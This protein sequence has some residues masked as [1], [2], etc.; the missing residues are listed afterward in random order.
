[1]NQKDINVLILSLNNKI[2]KIL[3]NISLK[4][5]QQFIFSFKT[6]QTIELEN[7]NE[8]DLV[9]IDD[10]DEK[11]SILKIKGVRQHQELKKIPI[12]VLLNEKENVDLFIDTGI[13]DY[14]VKPYSTQE[15][16][17]K[18][19]NYVGYLNAVKESKNRTLQFDALLNNTPYMA[20]FKNKDSQYIKVNREFREHSGKE[21]DVIFGRDDFFVWDGQIGEACREY[22]L[23]VMNERRQIIFDEV[24][25]GK[26]GYRQFNIYKAPVIDEFDKVVGTI[27]I[28]RDVTEL[29]NKDAKLNM[30]LE[31]IP[32]AVCLKDLN[33]TLIDVNSK[34]LDYYKVSRELVIG[35]NN[36][37]I[38][39]SL[40][41]VIA[42]EDQL[43]KQGMK[44]QKFVRTIELF[45]E[46]RV[47][48]VYKSPVFDISN[49]IIAI[50]GL[51]RDITED[52]KTQ[53]HIKTLAYTDFL[54]GLKNRR[55]LY[56]YIEKEKNYPET[57]LTVMFMDLDNF[58]KLND[59]FG[60]HYGDEALL[61][62]SKKLTALC[63][64][65]FVARIGGD[66]FVVVWK[67]IKDEVFLMNKINQIL[68]E[69]KTEFNKG[70]QSNII[71]VSMGVVN[72]RGGEIEVDHLL[73]QGDLALYKAKEKGKNQCVIY[74]DDLEKERLFAL[75]LEMD[76]R[77]AIKN[78]EI[79]LYY[80]PQY[81]CDKKLKGFEALFRW[82]NQKYRNVSVIDIIKMIEECHMID[83]IGDYVIEQ[84]CRFSKKINQ[85]VSEPL[86]VSMNIS[87]LQI[88][89]YNFVD[90]FKSFIEKVNISPSLVG[91]EI[92]ETV[93][94]E[95]MKENTKKLKELKELGV[96]ISLD[97]FGTGYSSLNYLVHLPLSQI[98]IDRSFVRGMNQGDEFIK[99]VKLIINIAHTLSLPIIAEGVEYE[100]DLNLLK[101]L[102]VDYI[103][104]YYFSKPVCEEEAL[105]LI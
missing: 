78:N 52:V 70:D 7:I 86:V 83:E 102:K 88:M 64:D 14:L 58:K 59:S 38:D 25:P 1:M 22:D 24:I 3:K 85:E 97:D 40:D 98:K 82:N 49:Q 94:M 17:L 36:P 68:L 48:E 90:K 81:T 80:Q 39:K 26:K 95:N 89:N 2:E 77:D 12:V 55:S 33:G 41:A 18:I 5:Y 93:L 79:E 103:Q 4:S 101:S 54:T 37:V 74:T 92:T 30:I 43:I 19:Q 50:V 99:L 8:F 63:E 9:I 32:F 13:N 87:A 75:G 66:E 46:E 44:S 65:A 6:H 16:Q 67:N 60:H 28:A 42:Y 35:Y 69:M 15:L 84:S 100:E 47:L 11:D 27:G 73:L 51:I 34:F 72:S 104:G 45:G 29:R 23:L 57:D 61:I 62:I 76:L 53:E 105:K 21:D 71:S 31:N 10:E 20:W 91:I 96:K 56:E